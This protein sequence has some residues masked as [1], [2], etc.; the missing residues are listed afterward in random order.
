MNLLKKK[1]VQDIEKSR[2]KDQNGK[3][4]F[5]WKCRVT[6]IKNEGYKSNRRQLQKRSLTFIVKHYSFVSPTSVP[7]CSPM[8]YSTNCFLDNLT[9]TNFVDF[10]KVQDTFTC[11]CSSKNDSN[12]LNIN[13]NV[14]KRDN[15][16][17]PRLLHN[18]SM[19]E[20]DFNKLTQLK[21][22]PVFAA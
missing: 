4:N 2:D 21:N 14:F 12:Y 6:M 17:D 7:S 15:K 18:L 20:A 11:F 10:W 19:W 5:I 22:Q 16:R 3:N 8:V 13:M 1:E 9:C